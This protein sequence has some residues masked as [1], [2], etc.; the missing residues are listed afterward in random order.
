MLALENFFQETNTGFEF[1]RQQSSDFA[2]SVA[3]DFNP[4]HDIDSRRFCVPGDLL[5][6]L[7][8]AKYGVSAQM[9]FVF[10]GMVGDNT[11]LNFTPTDAAHFS[12]TDAKDKTYLEVE[13]SGQPHH[14]DAFI[15]TL[16]RNY[17]AFSGRNFP[18]TLHPLLTANNVM[19]NA[20][21]PMVIYESMEFSID[22]FDFTDPALEAAEA[23]F[24]V[25]GK[26]AKAELNFVIRSGKAEVGRG[27]KRL[28]LSGLKPYDAAS[29]DA[30]VQRYL[31]IKSAYLSQA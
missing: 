5:F 6:S 19:I 26:R 22:R 10:K 12:I 8:L 9:R 14:D 7:V 28:V 11:A 2:K 24:S 23:D 3:G 18:H 30:L 15:E 21:R 17:V 31:D 16:T 1:S 20:D 25:N 4:L 27:V 13:R 29:A